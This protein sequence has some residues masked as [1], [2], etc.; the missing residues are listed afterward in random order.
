MRLLLLLFLYLTA[1]LLWGYRL[2]ELKGL[3][4]SAEPFYRSGELYLKNFRFAFTF[5][6]KLLFAELSRLTL[7]PYPQLEH[8][9]LAVLSLAPK[10]PSKKKRSLSAYPTTTYP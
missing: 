4:L 7:L 2:L 8:G 10:K 3:T 5:R 6:D 1:L 9:V